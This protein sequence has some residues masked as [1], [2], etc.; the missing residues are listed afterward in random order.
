MS[1]WYI[2]IF[3]L[4]LCSIAGVSISQVRPETIGNGGALIGFL[5]G[6]GFGG[7][8]IAIDEMLKGFSLRAFSATTVGLGVGCLVAYLVDS[9]GLFNH[10][11]AKTRWLIRM[12]LFLGC[13]Y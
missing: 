5:F 9:S 4:A 2:R 11:D 6:F 12:A 3:F 8:L 1:L 13:G 7:L 10:V